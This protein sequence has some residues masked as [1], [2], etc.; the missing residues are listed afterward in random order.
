[1]INTPISIKTKVSSICVYETSLTKEEY[2]AAFDNYYEWKKAL[3]KIF[4]ELSQYKCV[5]DI[6]EG[7]YWLRFYETQ[8]SFEM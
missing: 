7:L 3:I 2:N 8:V 6:E 1:M 5:F 4:P